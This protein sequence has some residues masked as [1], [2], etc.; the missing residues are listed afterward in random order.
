MKPPAKNRLSIA[1]ALLLP[2]FT[3]G[4]QWLFWETFKPFVWFLFFPTAYFSS[5]IGGKSVGF[6]STVVSAVLVVY[7]FMSPQ[8]SFSGKT[9]A[10]L[11]SVAVFLV[12]GFIFSITHER[13]ERANRRATAAQEEVL[14]AKEQLQAARIGQLQA[15]QQLIAE[16]LHRSEER[17]QQ[18]FNRAPVPLCFVSQDGLLVDFNERFVQLFGYDHADVPTLAAWWQLAYPDETYRNWVIATW[19][20][21]VRKATATGRDIE[22]I[23][24]RVT[25]RN[26]E[27]LT[28][29]ISGIILGDDLLASFFDVTE[30]RLAEDALKDSE[31]SLRLAQQL[32]KVGSWSWDIKCDRHV[33]SEEIYR[34]YGRDNSLPPAVYPE[35]AQYF[36]AESWARLNGVVEQGLAAGAPYE[37]DAEVMRA[38]GRPCWIVARGQAER[39]DSGAVVRLYGTVQEITE[40][41]LAEEEIRRLNTGLEQRVAERTAELQAANRELDAFAYAVSHDLRAPLRAM[42]GFSQALLE[43]YGEKLDGEARD[44][45]A[46]IILASS[47]MGALIDGLL[48]LSRSSR[49]EVTRER[50][51]L[52]AMAARIRSELERSEPGRR[53]EWSIES[54][55]WVDG[56]SRMLEIVMRNLLGNA[57]KY[58]AATTAAHI[59]F[60]ADNSA[61]QR[62]FCVADNG[63]GF[64]MRH[65]DR[66]FK[67]FQRLHR[68]DE[69]AGI[70]IGLA[71]VKRIIQRHGGNIAA[72]S[73]PGKGAI[74]SFS[75]SP[76]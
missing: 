47:N 46:E 28:M 30:R 18:L 69:F 10:N 9:P 71:T 62:C 34:I 48:T 76:E 27:V 58:T 6:V 36:A 3:C 33:W 41:K 59:G 73:E 20:A 23:E 11:Y 64:D 66:L 51:D 50:I 7:F 42:N 14:I 44:N 37:C 39:D 55:V 15:E 5:R 38:D 4:V 54:E 65:A 53:L 61:G 12:M 16:N 24:Y 70:G 75:L 49:G 21:A 35:V 32:A 25:A 68:Q 56:D 26:G 67:P 31:A 52:G 29:L 19:S 22:P 43:D 2:F 57:W 1:L 17:F 13:L 45:L 72:T 63:A 8:L 40:R 74:F 60:Y